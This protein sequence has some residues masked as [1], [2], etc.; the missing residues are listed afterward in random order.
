MKKLISLLLF[1]AILIS[2]CNN[3]STSYVYV[4]DNTENE[5]VD[6]YV[7]EVNEDILY[8]I[9]YDKTFLVDIVTD[10]IPLTFI[11]PLDN[12]TKTSTFGPRW[13]TVHKGVDLAVPIGTPVKA[14]CSGVVASMVS[15][16][17]GYGYNIILYHGDINGVPYYTRYAHLSEFADIQIGD[18]V[19]QGQVIAYS[20][21]TG[22]ST[23]PHLHFEILLNGIQV[24]PEEYLEF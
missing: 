12:Y 8:N 2:G 20:G 5:I 4:S 3:Y 19:N 24:D 6:Y 23:G 13:G 17:T 22:D 1:L 7:E 11:K 16:N 21:S 9:A 15:G 18:Y 14:S 10:K